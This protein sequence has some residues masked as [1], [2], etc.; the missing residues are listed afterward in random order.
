M[1]TPLALFL[2]ALL[3]GSTVLALL[4]ISDN[5]E[6]LLNA[7]F[8]HRVIVNCERLPYLHRWYVLRTKRVS[9]FLHKFVQSDEDRAVHSHPWPFLVIPIWRGYIEHTTPRWSLPWW[10]WSKTHQNTYWSTED[11]VP[12]CLEQRQRRVYPI[13]SARYRA[14]T[15]RHRVELFRALSAETGCPADLPAWSLFF[16]F[17]KEREWGFHPAQG[18]V[19]W[20]EWWSSH[21]CGDEPE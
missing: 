6:R 8:A 17:T 9:L 11:G 5:L 10:P 12:V 20:K 19:N 1:V 18:F 7:V 2:I 14:A 4:V 21:K 3:T 15:F 16:H 13:I